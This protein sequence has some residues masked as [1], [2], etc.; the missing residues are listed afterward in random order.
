MI[1]HQKHLEM[2]AKV[3]VMLSNLN[4]ADALRIMSQSIA[5]RLVSEL[6]LFGELHQLPTVK[7]DILKA[8][9]D[10]IDDI[11]R[12]AHEDTFRRN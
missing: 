6:V 2:C 12:S 5:S 11:G 8:I 9:A 4:G 10:T 1:D 7:A 3:I